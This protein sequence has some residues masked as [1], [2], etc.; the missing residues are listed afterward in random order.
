M[1]GDDVAPRARGS[2]RHF[3][4]LRQ[5]ICFFYVFYAFF[6]VTLISFLRFSA[7]LVF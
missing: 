4:G 6:V 5:L 1:T 2:R 3:V 7:A